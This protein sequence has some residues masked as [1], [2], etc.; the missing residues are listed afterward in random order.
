VTPEDSC[1]IEQLSD[2]FVSS[3]L[4]VK[5]LLVALTQ[6]NAFLYRRAVELD[7]NAT[8]GAL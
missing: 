6:T 2:V 8:G 4:N 5:E 7:A 1:S 3:N